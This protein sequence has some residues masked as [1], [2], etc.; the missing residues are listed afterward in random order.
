MCSCHVHVLKW[1]KLFRKSYFLQWNKNNSYLCIGHYR[2][3]QSVLET[4]VLT[5]TLIMPS[6][7]AQA[8]LMFQSI[9]MSLRQSINHD[10]ALYISNYLINNQP[11]NDNPVYDT[12]VNI[13]RSYCDVGLLLSVCWH[14][15]FCLI[16]FV[17]V[18]WS[19]GNLNSYKS[20]HKIKVVYGGSDSYNL[21]FIWFWWG[22]INEFLRK[23]PFRKMQ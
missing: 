22:F 21:L 10:N 7:A 14:N 8:S 2:D 15:G 17:L 13:S 19:F 11:M 23:I 9:L 1:A 12:T 6:P 16:N 20:W 5:S 3:S 18:D 4:V